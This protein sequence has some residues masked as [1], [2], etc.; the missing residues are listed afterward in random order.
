MPPMPAI[1]RELLLCCWNGD[2]AGVRRCLSSGAN[3]D[4]H[5][6]DNEESF[7]KTPIWGQTRYG[8]SSAVEFAIWKHHDAILQLLFD[9]GATVKGRYKDDSS[10]GGSA[11]T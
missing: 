10:Y 1:D 6:P 11:M 5:I 8:S 9:A 7:L 3:P 2:I 4:P